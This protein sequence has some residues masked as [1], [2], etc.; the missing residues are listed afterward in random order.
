[1]DEV[2]KQQQKH[3]WHLLMKYRLT[4]NIVTQPIYVSANI[5][6]INP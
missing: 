3:H 4:K 2:K 6:L 1:M 5:L